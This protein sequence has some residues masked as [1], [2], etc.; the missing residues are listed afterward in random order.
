[1]NV[2]Y[3]ARLLGTSAIMP[4]DTPAGARAELPADPANPILVEVVRGSIVESRHRGSAAIVDITGTVAKSWG[5]HTAPVYPRSAIKPLQAIP[6]IESGAADAFGLGDSEIALACASHGGEPR[7]T[8]TVAAWLARIG[9]SGEDLECGAH[10]PTHDETAR[11]MTKAGET[12]VAIHNNCSGKHTGFLTTAV[13]KGEATNGYIRFEH[14]VQQRILGVLEAMCGIDLTNAPRG[15]DG[16]SIP[17]IAIPLR[18]LA[19]GMA[20]FGAPDDLPEPRADAC[21]R[22][23]GAVAAEP[24]MVAGTGR[25]CTEIM[26]VTGRAVLLKTGAEGVFCAAIPEYGLGVALKC[27][28]GA[29]RAAEIMMSAVLRHIGVLTEEMEAKLARRIT[30]PLQNRNG[31]HVGDVRAAGAFETG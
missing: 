28:D 4:L 24:F 6:L 5:D 9:L 8:E 2:K 3:R 19:Y 18:N 29:T 1:M 10:W 27:D 15:I 17:T 7:H 22:I 20:R 26:M 23:A 13:H 12:P 31:I 25:Y 21:R 11:A 14:P 16:C 30:M